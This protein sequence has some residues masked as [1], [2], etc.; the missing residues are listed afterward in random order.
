[1]RYGQLVRGRRR[2]VQARRR[3]QRLPAATAC[4]AA[5][6]VARRGH[7]AVLDRLPG[8]RD[9]GRRLAA[10]HRRGRGRVLVSRVRH[11]RRGTEQQGGEGEVEERPLDHAVTLPQRQD[12]GR[13]RRID[14]IY[15][16]NRITTEPFRLS[17]SDFRLAVTVGRELLWEFWR[18]LPGLLRGARASL[19]HRRMPP[20]RSRFP[21]LAK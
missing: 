14:R 10:R 12:A 4:G 7:A 6:A 8:R 20:H 19:S 2:C 15:R 5:T 3:R 21:G 9:V 16:I 11:G 17:P 1:M 18:E 13:G